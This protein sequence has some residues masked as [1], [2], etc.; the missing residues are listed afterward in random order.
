MESWDQEF[1][2]NMGQPSGAA[3]RNQQ[4]SLEF[5][6]IIFFSLTIILV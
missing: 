6:V 1:E 3:L 5:K 4:A 2:T